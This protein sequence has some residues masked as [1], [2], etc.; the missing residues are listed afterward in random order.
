MK[1]MRG[2]AVVA[3]LL[4]ATPPLTI[5]AGCG[6]MVAT[7]DAG[8]EDGNR[9]NADGG[10]LDAVAD[11][12]QI[13]DSAAR[14][15]GTP[16]VSSRDVSV[17]DVGL[18]D[19]ST[20]DVGLPDTPPPPPDSGCSLVPGMQLV[21]GNF[22]LWGV[23]S[24]GFAIYQD[25]GSNLYAA[26]LTGGPPIAIAT[27]SSN[28]AVLV[29]GSV[30]LVWD[31]FPANPPQISSLGVWTAANGYRLLNS[32]TI[33]GLAAASPDG[34]RVIYSANVNGSGTVG[35]IHGVAVDGTGDTALLIGVDVNVRGPCF[36]AIQWAGV[37]ASAKAVA[38][39]C[40][41]GVDAGAGATV[42]TFSG[43]MWSRADVLAN[44]YDNPTSFFNSDSVGS[45][46]FIADTSM[47]GIL[48]SL[49][50]GT[51]TTIDTNVFAGLVFGNGAGVV[52]GVAT[53]PDGG[54]P[55]VGSLKYSPTAA[56]A[57]LALTGPAF[58][59]AGFYSG[60]G[61][62]FAPNSEW[63]YIYSVAAFNGLS[64]LAIANTTTPGP[65]LILSSVASAT[66]FSAGFTADSAYA[67]WYDNVANGF[68]AFHATNL[69]TQASVSL[70]A[71]AWND[72]ALTGSLITYNDNGVPN[73][74]NQFKGTADIEVLDLSAGIAPLK[75]VAQADVNYFPTGN[76]TQLVY[77]YS[78]CQGAAGLYVVAM[79]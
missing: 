53:S 64:D 29:Q 51:N 25:P 16:D 37:G 43:P 22:V 61:V 47:N 54:G 17:F 40:D 60:T 3:F 71:I 36:A 24:D 69:G 78:A 31:S 39:H 45:S 72:F 15:V 26:A 73:P 57:P 35:D 58:N 4:G 41:A 28:P 50:G 65:P 27:V 1:R 5:L 74:S 33:G 46:L 76:A 13:R 9:A 77:T 21:A 32:S 18:Q 59:L 70:A 12:V 66:L 8:L 7:A 48:V 75:V 30:V 52:Y 14:D 23:T 44:A 68:G 55:F 56:A 19:I 42:S 2:L 79:P 67:L 49:T 34:S 11:D 38:A 63:L 20:P 6:G 10:A 62:G